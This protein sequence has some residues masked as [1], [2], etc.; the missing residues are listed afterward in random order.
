MA[1]ASMCRPGA[2]HGSLD[3]A[4]ATLA[5]GR[6]PAA[7]EAPR[8]E[9]ILTTFTELGVIA[10]ITEALADVG[11]TTPFPIQEMT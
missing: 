5:R 4:R 7:P 8:N 10:E 6:L 2:R 1:T 11:I 3:S 9:D